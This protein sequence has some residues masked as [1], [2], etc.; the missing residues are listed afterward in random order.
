MIRQRPGA[1]WRLSSLAGLLALATL[2]AAAPPAHA[3][4]TAESLLAKEPP[5]LVERLYQQRMILLQELGE[6]GGLSGAYMLAYIIFEKTPERVLRLL[7][8]TARQTEFRPDLKT[9][10]TLE[11][12]EDG[13]LDE[14]RMQ[15]M[16]LK[17]V[18][19]LRYQLDFEAARIRWALDPSFENSVRQIEGF[20]E[21]YPLG[22][23]ET[24]AR[25]GTRVDIGA[26]LPAFLQDALTRKNM[27]TTLEN[28]R[29]WVNSDGR[30]RP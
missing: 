26:A 30:Y 24:L 28:C 14:Y 7:S 29:R 11:H 1:S 12:F 21:L 13:V 17:I 8:Q 15:I 16:F 20:W 27:P 25:F 9:V 3:Q 4:L 18:Y 22:D 6:R 23:T 19:R 10:R 5:G 2:S